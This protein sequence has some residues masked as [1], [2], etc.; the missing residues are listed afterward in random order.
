MPETPSPEQ[1]AAISRQVTEETVQRLLHMLE[2]AGSTAPV[3]RIRSSQVASALFGTIGLALFLVGVENAAS[4]IPVL[5]NAYGSICVGLV[6]L[7]ATGLLLQ[8]LGG[9]AASMRHPGSSPD[10]SRPVA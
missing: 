10:P 8:L 1:L 2:R 7:A 9:H 5:S 3:R 4:D 6:L